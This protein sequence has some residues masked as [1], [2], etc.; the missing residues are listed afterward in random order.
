MVENAKEKWGLS[1][2]E[3]NEQRPGL[4]ASFSG[5]T[6]NR[7]IKVAMGDSQAGTPHYVAAPLNPQ[8]PE[9][10]YLMCSDR[11]ILY[12]NQTLRYADDHRSMIAG[13]ARSEGVADL[14]ITYYTVVGCVPEGA[15]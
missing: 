1:L 6:L 8:A 5:E 7:A 3:K 12:S 13:W 10:E 11:V 9:L 15:A 2:L 14:A 4:T